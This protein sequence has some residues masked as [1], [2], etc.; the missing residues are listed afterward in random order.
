MKQSSDKNPLVRMGPSVQGGKKKNK[1]VLTPD[2]W[3]QTDLQLAAHRDAVASE[4]DRRI[5]VSSNESDG[6]KTKQSSEGRRGLSGVLAGM[7]SSPVAGS[8]PY[9]EFSVNTVTPPSSGACP[10]RPGFV[11]QGGDLLI[12]PSR[13]NCR[14]CE[15]CS[16]K[17][18][19]Q[20]RERLQRR[21][22][23]FTSVYMV[24]LTLD[25]SFFAGPEEAYWFAQDKRFVARMVQQ[26]RRWNYLKSPHY[27]VIFETQ[28]NGW[29]HWHLVLDAEYVP[30][31]DLRHPTK[32]DK[33]DKSRNL[34][35]AWNQNLKAVYSAREKENDTRL[36]PVVRDGAPRVGLGSVKFSKDRAAVL[37]ESAET[38]ARY[39]SKYVT[40]TPQAGWPEWVMECRRRLRRFSTSRGF[41]GDAPEEAESRGVAAE[42]IEEEDKEE[43]RTIRQR[44]RSCGQV[45]YVIQRT[46]C[47]HEDDVDGELKPSYQMLGMLVVPSVV[48]D[49]ELGLGERRGYSVIVSDPH[50][51][52]IVRQF[53]LSGSGRA[54]IQVPE[55][56]SEENEL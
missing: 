29:P 54:P 2:L 52:W 3:V 13:C 40:K 14:F 19:Q 48:L 50:E 5:G 49:K 35:A 15:R 21:F 6:R 9:L 53:T 41:W 39:V 56:W 17:L 31:D 30:V 22:A 36:A 10:F 7:T 51:Q 47:R 26:L 8:P 16:Y 44:L 32:Y 46:W 18:G 45:P 28:E 1:R 12:V 42:E 37:A 24:T 4:A 55:E 38:A 25:P 43:P 34:R 11:A 23:Q 33:G 27:A 20:L